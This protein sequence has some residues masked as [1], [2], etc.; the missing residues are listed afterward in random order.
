MTCAGPTRDDARLA[1]LPLRRVRPVRLPSTR[2]ARRGCSPAFSSWLQRVYARAQRDE[3][4]LLPLL[5]GCTAPAP[6][7]TRGTD[8]ARLRQSGCAGAIHLAA[9][10]PTHQR[11]SRPLVLPC[12]G[13]TW[14]GWAGAW[15][16]RIGV[17]DG[18]FWSSLPVLSNRVFG[19][20]H[21]GGVFGMLVCL[22]GAW[23]RLC[24]PPSAVCSPLPAVHGTFPALARRR[25][26]PH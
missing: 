14:L 21:A 13:V 26:R 8:A 23:P 1:R 16:G 6:T 15:L 25:R 7:P 2:P 17:S 4:L 24:S 12:R 5:D 18:L 19:L 22:G 11:V 10:L 9:C 20:K 3:A